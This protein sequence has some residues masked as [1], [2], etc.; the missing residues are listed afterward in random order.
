[1]RCRDPCRWVRTVVDVVN[2]RRW[3][4]YVLAYVSRYSSARY[5][6]Q[7]VPRATPYHSRSF[8]RSCIARCSYSN[9]HPLCCRIGADLMKGRPTAEPTTCTVYK[10]LHWRG[11]KMHQASNLRCSGMQATTALPPSTPSATAPDATDV[12]DELLI[13]GELFQSTPTHAYPARAFILEPVLE[14]VPRQ[15]QNIRGV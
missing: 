15:D 13:K 2:D 12:T 4:A 9:P 6:E 3:L 10:S 7:P 8:P 11:K 1:M 14:H 5:P